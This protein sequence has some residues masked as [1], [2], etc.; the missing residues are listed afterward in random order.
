[1]FWQKFQING[2]FEFD[3]DTLPSVKA[4]RNMVERIEAQGLASEAA[5]IIKKKRE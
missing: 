5:E 3:Q 4:V 1:M 2:R